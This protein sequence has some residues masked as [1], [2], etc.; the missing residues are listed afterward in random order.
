MQCLLVRLSDEMRGRGHVI[1]APLGSAEM[2]EFPLLRI[3][4]YY[5]GSGPFI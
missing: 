3:K 2:W 1:L 4:V 5:K